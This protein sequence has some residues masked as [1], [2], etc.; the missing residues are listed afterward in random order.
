MRRLCRSVTIIALLAALW[1]GCGST[2]SDDDLV[3][4]FL[5][6]DNT[7]LTQTDAVGPTSGDIDVVQD[8]CMFADNGSCA[9]VEPFEQTKIN[10][11]FQNNE[12]ADIRLTGY[13]VDIGPTS[14]TG[15]VSNT[16]SANLVGGRCLS[17]DTHCASDND[18]LIGG[19]SVPGSCKHTET[20]VTGILLFDIET[21]LH[22]IPGTYNVAITFA[23]SDPN[24]VFKV[25]TSY[26]ATFL[27]FDNCSTTGTGGQ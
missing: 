3:M 4:Q 26:V 7:G 8:C 11:V 20:T 23:G 24:Q 19:V 25:S 15:V 16:I 2:G 5:R 14:G 27:N 13:T 22:V 17:S 18:C 12:A 9:T 10:A 1:V 6:F 21:K